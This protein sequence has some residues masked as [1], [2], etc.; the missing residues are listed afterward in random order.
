MKWFLMVLIGSA[1]GILF[2]NLTNSAYSE[3]ANASLTAAPTGGDFTLFSHQ[4]PVS[5]K[6][7]KNKVVVL[8]FGYTYCPDIC[9]TNLGLL[10]LAY[11]QLTP[12]EQQQVQI[13]FVSVDP[14]RDTPQKLNE[15]VNYFSANIIGL[16]ANPAEIDNLTQRYGAVYKLQKTSA[17]DQTYSVDHSAFAYIIDKNGKLQTQLAHATPAEQIVATLRQYLPK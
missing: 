14:A 16:T 7:F 9:P 6:D 11:R 8:Y 5:L 15:Y 4:G 3:S 12:S 13:L 10:S 17:A 1:L 2:L